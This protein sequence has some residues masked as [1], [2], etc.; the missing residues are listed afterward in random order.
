MLLLTV[1][2]WCMSALAVAMTAALVAIGGCFFYVECVKLL[3][4][5]R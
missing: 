5:L 2:F 4:G 3:R 1:M